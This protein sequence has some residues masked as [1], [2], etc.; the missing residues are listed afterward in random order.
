L[1]RRLILIA[2]I[3]PKRISPDI[4]YVHF[5]KLVDTWPKTW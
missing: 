5:N 4:S 1:A 2:V 3:D